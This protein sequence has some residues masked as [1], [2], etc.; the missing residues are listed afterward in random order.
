MKANTA[1]KE[2]YEFEKESC[3]FGK[4][5]KKFSFQ[6]NEQQCKLQQACHYEKSSKCV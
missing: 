3:W 4:K 2:N 5:D 1:E 6:K